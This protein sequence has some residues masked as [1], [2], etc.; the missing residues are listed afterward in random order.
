MNKTT[1]NIGHFPATLYINKAFKVTLPFTTGTMSSFVTN[2]DLRFGLY[3]VAD[4]GTLFTGD[5]ANASGSLGNGLNVRGYMLNVNFG[6]TFTANSPLSLS[7]RN[8]LNDQNLMGTTGDYLSMGSGPH[9][10]G[11]TNAGVVGFQ[12]NTPYILTFQVTRTETN[13]SRVTVAITNTAGTYV[14]T[15]WTWS[16]VDTNGLDYHRFDAFAIRPA[17]LASVADYFTFPYFEVQVMP[18]AWECT[19]ISGPTVAYTG[20]NVTLT[21]VP[22]PSPSI[23]Q[24]TYSVQ[25]NFNLLTTNWVILQTNISALNYTDPSVSA[26]NAYY[27]VTSP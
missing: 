24:F 3:D 16:A 13:L 19:A 27:R 14:G 21:W 9:G 8:V 2:G 7:V 17:G 11:Y 15:N 22:T 26:S 10:G 23:A 1:T 12:P 6:P 18:M 25:R 20:N 5:D 4:G